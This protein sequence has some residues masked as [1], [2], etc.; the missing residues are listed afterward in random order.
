[1]SLLKCDLM[2]AA[3]TVVTIPVAIMFF[4]MQRY[5]ISGLIGGALKG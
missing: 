1:M 5:I 3:A 4:A 2:L